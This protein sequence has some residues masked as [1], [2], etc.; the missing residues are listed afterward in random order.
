[1]IPKDPIRANMDAT[2][3]LSTAKPAFGRQLCGGREDGHLLA[4]H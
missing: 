3:R 2:Q 1:M 4:G